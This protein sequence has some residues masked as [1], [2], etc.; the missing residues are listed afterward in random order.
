MGLTARQERFCLEY[1]KS[2]NATAAYKAAGYEPKTERA[3]IASASRMLTKV[4]V[5]E[6]LRELS[7]RMDSEG[8]ASAS[9][10]QRLFTSIARGEVQE[11]DG[12]PALLR[13]RLKAA[14]LLAKA[15]GLFVKKHEVDVD[16]LEI[17]VTL[18]DSP[19]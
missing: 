13:D 2:G 10:L 6:R 12:R 17:L 19:E 15:Q 9:E 4:D 14:E 16:G 3:A 1:A 18:E 5:R 8:I 7:E 11:R